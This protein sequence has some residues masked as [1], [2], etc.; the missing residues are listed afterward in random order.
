MILKDLHASKIFEYFEMI[1][2]IPRGSGNEQKISDFMVKFAQDLNLEVKQDDA[3]NI[4]IYKPATL[5]YENCPTIILQGHLDIVCEKN[6]DTIFDFE[7]QGL[8]LVI[9]GDW[10]RADGTTLG[11]DNGVAIAYQMAI[12]ADNTLSHPALEIFMTTEEETGMGGVCNM[13]P[14]YLNGRTLINLDTDNEGEFL[15]SCAGGARCKIT[16]PISFET[17]S[18]KGYNIRVANLIGGHSGA[19]I[20]H[21]RANANVIIG[22]ILNLLSNR[23]DIKIASIEGGSKDNVITRECDAVI[24]IPETQ[25]DSF[26]EEIS[27]IEGMLKNEYSA[28]DPDISI[29]LTS[30]KVDRTIINS[31]QLIDLVTLL[32]N[33]IV[34]MS[35]HIKDLVETS[36]NMGVVATTSDEVTITFA[37]RSSVASKKEE[38]ISKI[39]GISRVVGAKCDAGAAYPAWSYK[40]D[41]KI[42]E[43]AKEVYTKMYDKDPKIMA[44]HAGL[45]C[46]FIS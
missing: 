35:H 22:R 45:E 28:Q 43:L 18:N 13:H 19:E 14:E 9:D 16:L 10:I 15:V 11:A 41:S 37:L 3:Y 30:Q 32:P 17:T 8:N 40:E 1:S 46:G 21:E 31:Q 25:E 26:K 4:Y 36:L 7:Q 6:K 39:M 27:K 29:I 5:G 38:L 12:L 42:R 34:G 20:H 24:T 33:G 23:F 44:I 2:S